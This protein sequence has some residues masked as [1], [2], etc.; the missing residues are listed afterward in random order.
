MIKVTGLYIY[1]IKSLQG[2]EVE[3]CEILERGFRYDRRWM[4]IDAENGHVTQRTHPQ[5]SQIKIRIA[6]EM[7]VAS[8]ANYQDIEI[9]L[10]LKEG[11]EEQV[12]IW[13]DEVPALIADEKINQ[14]FSEIAGIPCKLVFMPENFSRRI[15]PDRARNQENV[16]FADGYPYLIISEASLQDLNARMETPLPMHR[17]RPNIVV[18]GVEPYDEDDWKD[19]NIQNLSFYGTH[20]CKR[21]VFTTIDQETGKK[22]PEPLKTLATYRREGS[23]V[24]FGLNAIAS[25]EGVIRVGDEI[26]IL[27]RR[28]G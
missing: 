26:T 11:E 10:I 15:N 23:E 6:G 5:L 2:I 21:C 24:I 18:R 19:F 28:N 27:N 17:F 13:S 1:P 14:W 20:P 16:S 25:S 4:I 12:T 22:G 3:K 7:I 9:P 8:H